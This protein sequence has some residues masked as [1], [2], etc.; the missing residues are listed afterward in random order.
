MVRFIPQQACFVSTEERI[1]MLVDFDADLE[2]SIIDRVKAKYHLYN[3]ADR[4]GMHLSDLI[5]CITRKYFDWKYNAAILDHD[6]ML[7]AIGLA[8]EEVLLED[9]S[10]DH[11]Q[12]PVE[13]DGVWMSPD[14]SISY[15]NGLAELK[16]ARLSIPKGALEPK[17]GW[18]DGWIRQMKGYTKAQLEGKFKGIK[19]SLVYRLAVYL[20]IPADVQAR[21]F[22]FTEQEITNFWAWVLA[23]KE[24]LEEAVKADIAPEPFAYVSSEKHTD[25]ECARCQY[26]VMCEM[27]KSTGG[28]L[29]KGEG[30]GRE[31]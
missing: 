9:S 8:L 30:H 13:V 12:E 10:G 22:T 2:R 5:Y 14:H 17:N 29:P 6:A 23:R 21:V 1:R 19:P 24:R 28:Y 18:P 4:E 20:V 11:R 25:W 15:L 16:S 31:G 27:Y 3:K 7:F 26:L